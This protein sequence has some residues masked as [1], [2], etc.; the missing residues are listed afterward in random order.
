MSGSHFLIL[1]EIS[2]GKICQ[3]SFYYLFIYFKNKI[4]TK[5]KKK[6][7]QMREDAFFLSQANKG[8]AFTAIRFR[9]L[10]HR[11][12]NLSFHSSNLI[13]NSFNKK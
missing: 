8:Q 7:R 13:A 5:I 2:V 9:L 11:S 4:K 6:E 3:Q 1:P 12:K 10:F